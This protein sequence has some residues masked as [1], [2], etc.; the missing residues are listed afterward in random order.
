MIDGDYLQFMASIWNVDEISSKITNKIDSIGNNTFPYLNMEFFW[1]DKHEL[2]TKVYIK[3]NQRLSYL[4]KYS[5][6]PSTVFKA[7]P[8]GFLKK[9]SKVNNKNSRKY[10]YTVGPDLF[11]TRRNSKKG[12]S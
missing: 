11:A 12:Q 1:S 3:Q 6:H 7:I 4:E 10:K 8:R 5:T 9:V 2:H